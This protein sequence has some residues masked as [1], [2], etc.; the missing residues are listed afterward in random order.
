MAKLFTCERLKSASAE[1]FVA[2]KECFSYASLHVGKGLARAKVLRLRGFTLLELVVALGIVG[3]LTT[4]AVP[5]LSE[6]MA[7]Q[8]IKKGTLEFHAALVF[9]R[10]EAIKRNA[11]V[12]VTGLSAD[13]AGGWS[14]AQGAAVL[15]RQTAIGNVSF[16]GPSS[17]VTF[18]NDG[19]LSGNGR[20][21]FEVRSVTVPTAV[22]RCVVVDLGGRAQVRSDR[23]SDGNCFNG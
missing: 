4:I 12:T 2:K 13:M 23:N 19:R 5:R 11:T 20:L 3:L 16:S 10:S 7:G 14:I 15:R 1:A 8:E 6:F 9:A 17:S 22:M 18:E 21:T